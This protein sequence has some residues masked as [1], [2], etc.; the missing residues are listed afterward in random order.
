MTDGSPSSGS[1]APARSTGVPEPVLATIEAHLRQRELR[2]E[3]LYERARR[4]RRLAQG[5][6][7]RLHANGAASV[8]LSEVRRGMA[9]LADWLHREGRGDEPLA[10]D[11]FQEAVEAVLLG[12][13]AA[14]QTLPGPS[15]LGVDPEPYLLGLGDVVGEV[16]RR[17]LDR[18]GRDD[19][20]GA[21]ADLALMERL[22][23]SLLRFDTTRAIV[24]LKPKQDTARA[25]LERT[26][27][28]VVMARFLAR[29]RPSDGAGAP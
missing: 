20:A 12:S 22:T 8:E 11:A 15:E 9:D 18:L 16:R 27:G 29:A 2:R 4:L 1:E 6:M 5:T 10:L 21:E 28:E 23:R 3:D 17:V 26:R 19:V 25:L 13:I 7:V 24:P 14:G